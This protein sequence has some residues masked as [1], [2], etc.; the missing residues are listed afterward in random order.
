MKHIVR[1]PEDA[2]VEYPP[3]RHVPLRRVERAVLHRHRAPGCAACR[4]SRRSASSRSGATAT[5]GTSTKRPT[6]TSSSPPRTR[7]SATPRSAT[8][9]GRRGSGSGATMM[10]VRKFMEMVFTGRPFTAQGDVRLRLRQRRRPVRRARSDD[11]EV[12]ARLL[13]LAS[14]PTPSSPRRRSS[15]STS[16]TR[17][18][19]WAASSPAWLESM[20]RQMRPDPSTRAA[21]PRDARRRPDQL[22]PGQRRELPARVAPEP[23]RPRRGVVT[24]G[25]GFDA[26]I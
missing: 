13:A 16:N 19:T 22:G 4:T 21:R 12:R 7:C 8:P 20:G 9:A 1:I 6:P 24:D 23:P 14:R 25:G 26:R 15:R 18:S 3:E 10:G 2:D 11:R 17:A 5:A